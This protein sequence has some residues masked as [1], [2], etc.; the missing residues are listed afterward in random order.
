MDSPKIQ[1]SNQTKEEKKQ[2]I[3]QRR[4]KQIAEQKEEKHRVQLEIKS[5]RET[6]KA[7]E[8]S[9]SEDALK[10]IDAQIHALKSFSYWEMTPKQRV[11][12][13]DEIL[14]LERKK[15]V[16]KE[17]APGRKLFVGKIG[18]SDLEKRIKLNPPLLH[19]YIQLRK[20][21]I[22]KLFESF[23]SVENFCWVDEKDSL[24]V[25]Y[26]NPEAAKQALSTFSIFEERKERVM[27]IQKQLEVDRIPCYIAPKSNFYVRWP[28]NY[29]EQNK[30]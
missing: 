23:G 10:A 15:K 7:I 17:V 26:D 22:Q 20:I 29:T 16:Q 3:R 25:I 5:K 18:F 1:I 8:N 4:E 11:Q 12:V 28:K 13:Q 21:H 30:Q 24:F 27:E 2:A 6:Q 14:M 9:L 19:H